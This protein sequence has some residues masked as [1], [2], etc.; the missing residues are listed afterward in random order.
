MI[1]DIPDIL[2]SERSGGG[3]GGNWSTP[4]STVTAPL[5]SRTASISYTQN[6]SHYKYVY[7]C[8]KKLDSFTIINT[9]T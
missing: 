8:W 9:G 6:N 3:G 1:T 7:K 2:S 5:T 4:A